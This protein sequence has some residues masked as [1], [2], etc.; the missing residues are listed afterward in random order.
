MYSGG[1]GN[2]MVKGTTNG[3]L[4]I[5]QL[6]E[7]ASGKDVTKYIVLYYRE[8]LDCGDTEILRIQ[9]KGRT[10]EAIYWLRM[11]DEKNHYPGRFPK[12]KR[13]EE[14]RTLAAKAGV[15]VELLAKRENLM[16]VLS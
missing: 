6:D 10:N 3:T 8:L 4:S 1:T 9:C 13:L 15:T 16:H 12:S 2:A 11:S 14:A 5:E 7:M